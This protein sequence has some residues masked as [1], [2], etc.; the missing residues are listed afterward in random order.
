MLVGGL[1]SGIVSSAM[2]VAY[3]TYYYAGQVTPLRLSSIDAERLAIF[4]LT[5]PLVVL[6]LWSLRR[7][8]DDLLIRERGLR[9]EAESE[10][11]RVVA[12]LESGHAR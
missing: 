10:R 11:Q 1:G 4:V 5:T 12:I 2:A 6:T 9:L 3:A 8:L 7:R